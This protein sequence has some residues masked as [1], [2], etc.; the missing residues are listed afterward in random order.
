MEERRR[1]RRKMNE[2]RE[3]RPVGKGEG[4]DGR[5]KEDRGEKG[6]DERKAKIVNEEGREYSRGWDAEGDRGEEEGNLLWGMRDGGRKGNGRK[7]G[8]RE[9][10]RKM[11]IEI[12]MGD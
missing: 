12:G 1:G 3:G 5:R 4:R 6:R 10:E 7:D 9:R 2:G 8:A 11:K